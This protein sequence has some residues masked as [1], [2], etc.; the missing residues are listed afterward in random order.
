MKKDN[1]EY[2][3]CAFCG[4]IVKEKKVE[5]DYRYKGNLYIIEKV[6]AGVCRQCGEKYLT[7][8]VAEEIERRIHAQEKWDRTR[9]VPVQVYSQ[10]A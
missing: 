4:G 5:L 1:H 3:D 10:T 7:A 2:G 9:K 8:S 6:P